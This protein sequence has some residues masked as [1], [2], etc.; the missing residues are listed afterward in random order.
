MKMDLESKLRLPSYNFCKLC[1]NPYKTATEHRRNL[2][3]NEDIIQKLKK[4]DLNLIV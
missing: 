3:K 4:L 1:L 2:S